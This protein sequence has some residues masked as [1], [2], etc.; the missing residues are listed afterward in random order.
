MPDTIPVRGRIY[1]ADLGHGQ[2]P[3]LVVSNNQR[4]RA[5]GNFLALRITTTPKPAMPTIVE[6]TSA[7]PLVG[8]ALCDDLTQ[9][10]RDEIVRDVGAASPQTMARVAAGIRAALALP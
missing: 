4:N 5:L 9:L 1:M 3:W 6:L 7:D 8:R 10:F 2:K